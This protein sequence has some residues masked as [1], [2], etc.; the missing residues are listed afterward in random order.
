M[1]LEAFREVSDSLNG[2][3]KAGETLEAR[4]D[5]ERASAE[6]LSLATKRWRN[7]V[8]A[9]IDV[10][11][12]QRNLFEAQIGVAEAREAQLT[13][14]VNLYKAVGGGWDPAALEAVAGS[15]TP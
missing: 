3:Y 10:L 11:D 4:L 8:L 12:A 5:L 1:V 6:Y 15:E 14:L 9:Y 2:F 13:A 7:G